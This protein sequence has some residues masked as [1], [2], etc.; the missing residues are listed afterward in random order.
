MNAIIL[1][2]GM[3][4]RLRPLTEDKPKC[5]VS[6]L[7]TPMIERQI[8]FL[9]ESGIDDITL[10]GGYKYEKLEY[11][12]EKYG[13]RLIV[14]PYFETINN[15]S[16]IKEVLHLFRGGT[17]I[18]EGDVYIHRNIFRR[19]LN[20]SAYFAVNKQNFNNEWELVT[21]ADMNVKSVKVG[22]GSGFIMSGVSYWTTDDALKICDEIQRLYSNGGYEKLFWDNAAINI[23]PS[24]NVRLI[25]TD[26]LYEIDTVPELMEVEKKLK[27]SNG[28]Q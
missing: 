8:I 15:I 3:G 17:F 2:A 26:S 13:I 20:Q 12:M 16:S 1:A 9:K 24:L 14:N 10:V 28:G 25:P 11:L 5:L 19:D 6:V 22:D 18:I 7:G 4:T 21:D 23:L 27:D